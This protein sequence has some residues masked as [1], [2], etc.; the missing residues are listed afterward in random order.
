MGQRGASPCP[1]IPSSRSYDVGRGR[2]VL[3]D[4]QSLVD[5]RRRKGLLML[6]IPRTHHEARYKKLHSAARSM[7]RLRTIYNRHILRYLVKLA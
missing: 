1:F 2:A 4:A 6:I 5:E 7:T 3:G